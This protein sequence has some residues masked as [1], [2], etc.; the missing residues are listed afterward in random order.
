MIQCL[1]GEESEGGREGGGDL[2]VWSGGRSPGVF[3]VSAFLRRREGK[4][5]GDGQ[6]AGEQGR[7][8]RACGTKKETKQKL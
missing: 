7:P 8:R 3:L 5:V 2:F 4:R 6:R 1:E